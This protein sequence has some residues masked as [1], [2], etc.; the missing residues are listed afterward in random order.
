MSAGSNLHMVLGDKRIPCEGV[1]FGPVVVAGQN[2]NTKS[3]EAIQIDLYLMLSAD[4]HS[5]PEELLLHAS[6]TVLTRAHV[7]R[8]PRAAMQPGPPE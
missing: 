4:Y 6:E 8:V 5:P 2:M 3:Q 1:I 7:L